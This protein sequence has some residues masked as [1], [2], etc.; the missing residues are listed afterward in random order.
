MIFKAISATIKRLRPLLGDY[1]H[2]WTITAT[3][4]RL[5]PLMGDFGHFW[6]KLLAIFLK[7]TAMMIF[8]L[9]R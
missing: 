4:G 3:F 8:L 9:H 1:G 2:Y 6:S 5:R 7:T